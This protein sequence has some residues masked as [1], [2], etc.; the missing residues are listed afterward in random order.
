M[1]DLVELITRRQ[2][3]LKE[4]ARHLGELIYAERPKAFVKRMAQYWQV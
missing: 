4:T 2:A 3:E 1:E